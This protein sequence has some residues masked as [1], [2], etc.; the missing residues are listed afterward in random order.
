MHPQAADAESA[1]AAAKQQPPPATAAITNF[2]A[3]VLEQL[4]PWLQLRHQQQRPETGKRSLR[5]QHYVPP[6]PPRRCLDAASS[7]R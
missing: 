6:A 7:S 3:A 4:L 1:A 5:P 2:A